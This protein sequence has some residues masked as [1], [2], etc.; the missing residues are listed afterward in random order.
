MWRVGQTEEFKGFK[1][2]NKKEWK[3]KNFQTVEES[4]RRMKVRFDA[5]LV[6]QIMEE[7]RGSAL[8][9]LYQIKM[10]LQQD[11]G[12]T[13]TVT[14]LPQSKVDK[15]YTESK[16]KET[17]LRGKMLPSFKSEKLRV[18][19]DKMLKYEEFKYD[20]DRKIREEA[21]EDG[22]YANTL[23][24]N[25]RQNQLTLMNEN[26]DYMRQW[27]QMGKESWNANKQRT[28]KRIQKDE[29]LDKFLTKRYVDK[30]I[31]RQEEA[32]T[33]VENGVDEFV[34]NMQR[35][36]IEDGPNLAS[37][38]RPSST[39][40]NR[41]LKGFSYAA[42]MNKIKEKNRVQEFQR[43]EKDI[44]LRKQKVDQ[45][46]TEQKVAHKNGEEDLL[47]RFTKQ[48]EVENRQ[49]YLKWRKDEC[50]QV[51]VQNRVNKSEKMAKNYEKK[52]GVIEAEREER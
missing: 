27:E 48:G 10:S 35:Q 18:V 16:M 38:D 34:E 8:R 19:E 15:K 24:Q 39:K 41:P 47:A 31:K 23:L 1:N 49:S 44:R 40:S 43:K 32:A 29:D 21:Y 51:E 12:F 20:Q 28:M 46:K 45:I 36:G 5:K 13:R 37:F 4:L 26:K 22:M 14:N 33:E 17:T 30:K 6:N 7:E 25:R 52:I 11:Q 9:L 3:V 42:T 2:R 50:K